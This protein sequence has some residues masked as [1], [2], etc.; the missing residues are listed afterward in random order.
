MTTGLDQVPTG[1]YVVISYRRDDTAPHAGRLF[2]LLTAKLGEGRVFIDVDSIEPGGDFVDAI[3]QAVGKANM[4]IAMIGPQW[5]TAKN[6]K[7]Q[8]RID[9]E[10]D[11]VRLEIETA[12]QRNIRVI[13]ILV[14][15][16]D[17]PQ[18]DV[19]P[20]VLKPLTRRNAVRIDNETFRTDVLP[21]IKVVT[22]ALSKVG[23][24]Q[25]KRAKASG[26]D[27]GQTKPESSPVSAASPTSATWSA[28]LL[29]R[30][31]TRA[32]LRLT[33][34]SETHYV[35]LYEKVTFN[36]VE[37]DG[38]IVW[39]KGARLPKI[40]RD[41]FQLSDGYVTRSLSIHA[42]EKGF[43]SFKSLQLIVDGQI[44]YAE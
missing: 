41:V 16:A 40:S 13:P 18:P 8:R 24:S 39:R 7:G 38:K 44:L 10:L 23:G 6:E 42:E 29:E 12:L 26:A 28:T 17:M 21:V 1:N 25:F 31:P 35:S 37:V 5:L 3:R 43:M 33:L 15:G 22:N 14:D 34:T 27:L 4:V 30:S 20:E 32:S 36:A 2:D 19:L 9:D 11:Y